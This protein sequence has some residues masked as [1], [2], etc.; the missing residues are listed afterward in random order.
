MGLRAATL[1]MAVAALT[2]GC[3]TD[4]QIIGA[5]TDVNQDFRLEYERILLE[6]GTRV[7]K[8]P[9][10]AAYAAL[11]GAL[12]RLG[13]QVADQSPDIGY[14]NVRAPAPRPLSPQEW[15]QA[16]ERDL[17]RMRELASRHVGLMARFA[18]FEPE[19]LDIVINAT[20]LEVRDGTEVSLTMR[21]RETAPPKSGRPRRD[22]APPSAVSLGLDKI[23][24]EVDRD[25]KDATWRR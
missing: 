17:P 11:Q 6:K 10:G 5:L 19:G 8:V 15:N 25:L 21:M 2:S 14:L 20:T 12:G 16:A 23:W 9:R 3:V 13:M 18:K 24:R 22:Y 7:Y 4:E 1:C